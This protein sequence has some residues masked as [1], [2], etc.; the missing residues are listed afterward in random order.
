M[1]NNGTIPKCVPGIDRFVRGKPVS[2]HWAPDL[3]PDLVQ[4]WYYPA[5]AVVVAAVMVVAVVRVAAVVAWI[6]REVTVVQT[7]SRL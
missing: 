6:V 1:T 2:L 3:E 7:P 4:H 5:A